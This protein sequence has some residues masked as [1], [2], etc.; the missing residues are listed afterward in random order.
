MICF[1][2]LCHFFPFAITVWTVLPLTLALLQLFCPNVFLRAVS[3][4]ATQQ[5][6]GNLLAVI[7]ERAQ[8]QMHLR[9]F[10][11]RKRVL[12]DMDL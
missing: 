10:V 8:S 3:F 9:D 7:N 11:L 4:S 1:A 12:S 2:F 6:I 5:Y